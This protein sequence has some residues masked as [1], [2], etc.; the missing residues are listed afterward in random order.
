MRIFPQFIV[1]KCNYIC[2]KVGRKDQNKD[3]IYYNNLICQY[4]FD[5]S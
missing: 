2:Y 1:E 4:V 3:L 5:N